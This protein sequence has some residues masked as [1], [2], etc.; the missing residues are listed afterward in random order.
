V[1]NEGEDNGAKGTEIRCAESVSVFVDPMGCKGMRSL[2]GVRV[3]R[4]VSGAGAHR[5]GVVGGYRYKGDLARL[6]G[7]TKMHTQGVLERHSGNPRCV[8]KA[9]GANRESALR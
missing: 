6:N 4:T 5:I 3:V 2:A 1:R 7:E 8:S 9:N